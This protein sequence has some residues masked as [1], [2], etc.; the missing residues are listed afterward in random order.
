MPIRLFFGA[1]PSL[2]ASLVISGRDW[3]VPVVV[4]LAVALGAVAWSYRR[5]TT[6]GAVRIICAALKLLGLLT[7][8]AVLLDPLWSG[9]RARQGANMFVILADNSQGLRIKDRGASQSRGE[10]MRDLLTGGTAKWPTKMDENFQV[11]R[12]LFDSRLQSTRDFSELNFDGRATSLGTALRDIADRYQGQPLSGVLLLTAGNATDLP[13]GRLDTAGLPPVYPVVMGSD[14]TIKDISLQRVTVSQT[15]FEDAPVSVQADVTQGGYSGRNIV[16]QLFDTSGKKVNEQTL[17]AG[18]DGDLLP[19]R[20][21]LKPEP[22]GA[23]VL[24]RAGFRAG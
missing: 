6:H 3:L 23:V 1:S 18:D 22:A 4:Y 7:L 8:G 19:F 11:R 2:L 13:D 24:S 20:F 9:V 5:D 15:A 12:Y 17:R 14:D 10:V 16:A 21:Q